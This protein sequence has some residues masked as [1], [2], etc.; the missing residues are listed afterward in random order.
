VPIAPH[1]ILRADQKLIRLC[2]ALIYPE[3][4]D[5]VQQDEIEEAKRCKIACLQWSEAG[6]E[7]HPLDERL[8]QV[9]ESWSH[10]LKGQIG[11]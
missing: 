10:P 6:D 4:L 2:G 7:E 3:Q 5:K 1:H 9:M 8:K 11:Q